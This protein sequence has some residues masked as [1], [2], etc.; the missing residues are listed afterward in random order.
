MQLRPLEAVSWRL[1]ASGPRPEV[2]LRGAEIPEGDPRKRDRHVYF[3]EW[4]EHRPTPVYDRY[5]L[6]SGMRFAGPAIV[7]E[8]E[9]TTII[10]PH[11][12]AE[13]DEFRN[14][15]VTL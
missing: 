15:H 2:K 4:G 1:L 13:V 8:R 12:K 11:G 5:L 3:P 7:E 14:L 9:S 6:R 10:G